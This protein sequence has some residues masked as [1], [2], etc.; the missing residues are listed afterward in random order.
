M[1]AR[2]TLR[3][4]RSA[5][6]VMDALEEVDASAASPCLAARGDCA[7]TDDAPPLLTSLPDE[8][9]LSIAGHCPESDLLELSGACRHLRALLDGTSAPTLWEPLIRARHADCIDAL[10]GGKVPP[11]LAGTSWKC[12][13]F[14]FDRTWLE[15]ARQRHPGRVLLRMTSNCAA[16][17][18]SYL[19]VPPAPPRR[20]VWLYLRVPFFDVVLPL[21]LDVLGIYWPSAPTY[22]IYDVT[23]F[24]ESHPGAPDLLLSVAREDDCTMSFD[25][26]NHTER[27]RAILRKLVVPGLEEMEERPPLAKPRPNV[28]ARAVAAASR[29]V[30]AL[31]ELPALLW[32]VA[33]ARAVAR[34]AGM[35]PEEVEDHLSSTTKD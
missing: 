27:A 1:A 20:D 30:H 12:H 18:R 35:Q 4:V 14:E 7:A 13:A 23:P 24:L 22:G 8:V 25:A 15:L 6:S 32:N 10:F 19:G 21:R 33:V 26:A 28:L 2:A 16:S 29:R 34:L 31:R 9:I 3:P 5:T 17:D 11:P